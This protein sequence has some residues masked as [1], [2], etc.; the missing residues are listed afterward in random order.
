MK[1][2]KTHPESK[3]TNLEKTIFISHASKDKIIAVAFVDIIL[4]GGLSVPIDQIFCVS[5]DGTKIKSGTDWRN[6]ISQSLS[7]AKLNFLLIT[8]NYKESE[9]CLNEMGA[10]WVTSAMVLALIVEPIN[11]KTVGVIQEPNQIEKLLDEKSLDRIKDIVQDTLRIPSTL[12]KSDRW[13]AKKT[14]FI[15]KVQKNITKFPFEVPMDRDKFNQLLKEANDLKITIDSLIDEKGELENLISELKKAKDKTEVTAIIKKS[16]PS[17]EF[18]DFQELCKVVS[19]KLY[20]NESIIN[21]VIFKDYTGKEVTIKWVNNKTEI[22]EAFA[23]DYINDDLEVRWDKT[24][25]MRNI[26]NALDKVERF[27]EKNLK[28]DFY[29]AF[30]EKYGEV[31]P[32]ISNKKFWEEVFDI[33]IIFN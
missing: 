7:S 24:N 27:L 22:D 12:I 13:T 14:E 11:Y 6:S 33:A 28:E 20:Q 1:P 31:L 8:P 18:Q 19:K 16:K 5:T 29:E 25:E 30:E 10:A 3:N 17:T 21:G 9:V 23:N 26:K 2:K 15:S 4:H 32:E